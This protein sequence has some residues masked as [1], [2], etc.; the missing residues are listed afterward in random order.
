[1]PEPQKYECPE[2]GNH[3]PEDLAAKQAS[4]I[5]M[6]VGEYED[7][8]HTLENAELGEE[9]FGPVYLTC[10]VCEHKWEQDEVKP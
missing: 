2:C 4:W 8:T 10:L 5:P 6:N 9:Y 3:D 1:M 7:G